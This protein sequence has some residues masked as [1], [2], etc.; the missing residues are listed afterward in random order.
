MKKAMTTRDPQETAE[1][2]AELR[3]G[4]TPDGYAILDPDGI[5][6]C[7][8]G[9]Y[10]APAT[11]DCEAVP[12]VEDEDGYMVSPEEDVAPPEAGAA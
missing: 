12:L 6:V 2:P 4:S 1:R 3:F 10:I 8:D 9:G 11:G 7:A 5:A